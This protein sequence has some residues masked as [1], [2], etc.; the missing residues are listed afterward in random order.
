MMLKGLMF[1]L[2]NYVRTVI[3]TWTYSNLHAPTSALSVLCGYI[4]GN[5]GLNLMVHATIV[6]YTLDHSTKFIK[7]FF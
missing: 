3:I 5:Y 6:V 7:I 1:Y 4:L 2:K